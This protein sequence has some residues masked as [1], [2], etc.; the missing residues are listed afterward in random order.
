MH[1]EM[2]VRTK[3]TS[4]TSH[5]TLLGIA[6]EIRDASG[7]TRKPIDS[8][9]RV[10]D[11]LKQDL[12]DAYGYSGPELTDLIKTEYDVALSKTK[13]EVQTK[14]MQNRD[15]IVVNKQ[16]RDETFPKIQTLIEKLL[17]PKAA[18]AAWHDFLVSCKHMED[19]SKTRAASPTS[20][21]LCS[22]SWMIGTSTLILEVQ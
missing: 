14:R 11:S 6:K 9:T 21:N 12:L 15:T 2:Q 22:P 18:V 10:W 8:D 20:V 5:M 3:K 19:S 4:R 7:I 16:N 17:T 13:S 1:H